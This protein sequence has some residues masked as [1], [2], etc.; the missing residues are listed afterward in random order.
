[1]I[2][3]ELVMLSSPF[4]GPGLAEITKRILRG[5]YAK[6]P[7]TQLGGRDRGADDCTADVIDVVKACLTAD[8]AARP[9]VASLLQ[10]RYVAGVIGQSDSVP[11]PRRLQVSPMGLATL[12]EM[13]AGDVADSGAAAD[14]ESYSEDSYS[15]SGD[16]DGDDGDPSAP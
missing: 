6:I 11:S 15:S 4:A 12:A 8:P 3:Y 2:L 16:G 5:D 9:T 7:T 13:G 1:M 10:F 14:D